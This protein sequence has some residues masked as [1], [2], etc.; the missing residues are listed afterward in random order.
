VVRRRIALGVVAAASLLVCAMV[1]AGAGSAAPRAT[2]K[3][4]VVLP[5]LNNPFFV[6]MKNGVNAAGKQFGVSVQVVDGQNDV[7]TQ[8]KLIENFIA[9]KVNALVVQPV[10]TSGIVAGIKEANA[11]HIPVFTTAETPTGGQIVTKIVFN[12]FNNGVIGGQTLGKAMKK[13][14]KVA[15]LQG[16]LGTS[17]ARDRSKGFEKGFKLACPSCSIVA[18]QPANFD[19]ATALTVTENVL[20][21]NRSISGV[22]A[23]NDEMAL[24]ALKAI[25]GAGLKGVKIVGNDGEAAAVSVIV[26]HQMIATVAVPAFPQGYMA[27]ELAAKQLNGKKVCSQVVE[28]GVLITAANAAKAQALTH[29]VSASGRYWE[30]C[31]K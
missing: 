15:E 16:I 17:T 10:D 19:R 23:A 14:S 3:I 18:K 7:N 25:Q 13:G 24:G 6:D 27:V 26:K 8:T 30:S 1:A 4:G 22:Y 5:T 28:R 11:A 20:Q 21:R 12:E 29:N 31:V 9:Q 2:F